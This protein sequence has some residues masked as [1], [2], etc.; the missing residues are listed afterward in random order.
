MESVGI[1][2]YKDGTQQLCVI[3]TGPIKNEKTAFLIT[4][5]KYQMIPISTSSKAAYMFLKEVSV[6]E[7]GLSRWAVDEAVSSV[8]E[9]NN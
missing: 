2:Q 6:D 9:Y 4:G 1:I 7:R 5:P 8:V 3:C